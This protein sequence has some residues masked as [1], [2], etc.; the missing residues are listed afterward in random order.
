MKKSVARPEE[1][2]KASYA[3]AM[4]MAKLVVF[5]LWSLFLVLNSWFLMYVDRLSTNKCECAMTWHRKVLQGVFTALVVI[6]ATMIILLFTHMLPFFHFI[7]AVLFIVNIVYII[8]AFL[9]VRRI[10]H[11]K[12]ACAQTAAFKVIN[13]IN[14]IYIVMICL[15]VFILLALFASRT[16]IRMHAN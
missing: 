13:I 9:F 2:K 4:L 15:Y 3:S 8:T 12:C 16:W 10:K 11:E 6:G 1:S 5:V 7:Q 14:I